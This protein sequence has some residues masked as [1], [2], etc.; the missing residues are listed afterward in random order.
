MNIFKISTLCLISLCTVGPIVSSSENTAI[1]SETIAKK[2]TVQQFNWHG[3]T[4]TLDDSGTLHVPGGDI[5]VG[6]HDDM[7]LLELVGFENFKSVKSIKLDGHLHIEG[8][9]SNMFSSTFGYS[10]ITSI[11]NLENLDTRNVTDMANMFSFNPKLEL[12]E[13]RNFNTSNVTDMA[14]MFSEDS[15]LIALDVGGFDTSKVTNMSSMFL[16][17]KKIDNIDPANFNT[18]KVTDMS[19]MFAGIGARQLNLSNFDT[20]NVTNMGSMFAGSTA[21]FIDL[22]SFDTANVSNMDSMLDAEFSSLQLGE[23]FKFIGTSAKLHDAPINQQYTGKWINMMNLS[24]WNAK[25]L[26]SNYNGQ[27]DSGVFVWQE[28]TYN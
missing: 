19:M 9:A 23:R 7:S 26:M 11:V 17:V 25:D 12:I 15:G 27:T 3:L 22:S 2:N 20:K 13:L 24:T 8:S 1:A 28:K 16:N 18:S 5:K 4:L 21:Q 10:E 14:G 6:A